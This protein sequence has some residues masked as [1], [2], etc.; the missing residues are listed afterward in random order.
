MAETI[1]TIEAVPEAWPELPANELILA[2]AADTAAWAWQRIEAYCAHRW[3]P[4]EVMWLVQGD[5][6]WFPPIAPAVITKVESWEGGDWR[7]TVP[8]ASPFGRLCLWGDAHRITATVG[9]DNPPPPLV[10]KAATRLIN[11]L[12]QQIDRNDPDLWAT[13]MRWITSP[14]DEQITVRDGTA[15]ITRGDKT[16]ESY[17]RPADYIAKALQ[18]SGAADL[19]RPYRRAY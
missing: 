2:N 15:T 1:R 4:R 12:C 16:Q 9:A 5:G 3:T 10:L 6:E 13:S 18:Y 14:P 8:E 11:Y 7:P 19:L 17:T